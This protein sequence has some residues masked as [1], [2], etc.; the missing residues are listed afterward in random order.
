MSEKTAATGFEM[1]KKPKYTI[2]D[3]ITKEV[4]AKVNTP[5]Q[6]KTFQLNYIR[7]NN[8]ILLDT[9]HIKNKKPKTD[10]KKLDKQCEDLWRKIVK[11]NWDYKCAYCGRQTGKLEAHHIFTRSRDNTRWD[12]QNGIC[13]CVNH[14][15]FG[16]DGFSAHS[17]PDNFKNWLIK[18]KGENFYQMLRIKSLT[19]NKL[20]KSKLNTILFYLKREA[21][22]RGIL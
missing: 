18:L 6:L 4:L 5:L 2:Y 22:S 9:Y 16:N 21:E 12:I 10:K 13:L 19:R 15:K 1:R 17:T 14:H 8:H 3:K 11:D 7:N 20:N